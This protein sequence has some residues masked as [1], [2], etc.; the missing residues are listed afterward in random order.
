MRRVVPLASLVEAG[1][2]FVG[3]SDIA[4]LFGVTRQTM[5]KLLVDGLRPAPL[6]VHEGRPSLWRLA[7]VLGWLREEKHYPVDDALD[8]VA[9]AAM[10]ANRR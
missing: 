9:W 3:L 7:L 6:P 1:P 2:D 4:E 5:R 10:Q 8:E